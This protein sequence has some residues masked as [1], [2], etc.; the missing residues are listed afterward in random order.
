M[1]QWSA[2]LPG[3]QEVRGSIPGRGTTDFCTLILFV[4][5]YIY[6]YMCVCVC[7]Y[8]TDLLKISIV[9]SLKFQ[10]NFS[11]KIPPHFTKISVL[12]H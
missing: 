2:R 6:I 7:V 5:I 3:M 11:A 9:I 8:P 10:C 4:Y 1:V 12:Y